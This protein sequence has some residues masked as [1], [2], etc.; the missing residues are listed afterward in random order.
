[1]SKKSGRDPDVGPG[2]ELFP[3]T[4]RGMANMGPFTPANRYEN[5]IDMPNV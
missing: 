5:C 4:G 1:M 3:L 2:A